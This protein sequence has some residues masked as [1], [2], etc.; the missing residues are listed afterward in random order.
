MF[1][2]TDAHAR[3]VFGSS[4]QLYERFRWELED[5][6]Y[7]WQ[8][9][10]DELEESWRAIQREIRRAEDDAYDTYKKELREQERRSRYGF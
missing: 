10:S 5:S 6:F 1:V 9:A 7:V 8:N 4:P 2:R 3:H